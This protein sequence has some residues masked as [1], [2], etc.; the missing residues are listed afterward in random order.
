[1]FESGVEAGAPR[2]EQQLS[3]FLAENWPASSR[4]IAYDLYRR[5]IERRCLRWKITVPPLPERLTEWDRFLENAPANENLKKRIRSILL[6][7][8]V[9]TDQLAVFYAHKYRSAYITCYLLAAL[10]VF[11]ALF[12]LLLHVDPDESAKVLLV[13]KFI[14]VIIEFVFIITIIVVYTTGRKHLWHEKWLEYRAL[15][16]LLRDSRFLAFFAEYGSIQRADSFGSSSSTWLLWYLRATVRE[17][18]L[19]QGVLDGTYQSELLSSVQQH[20]IS[21]QLDYHRTNAHTLHRM[22]QLLH[23]FTDRCFLAT[24]L[25]LVMFL[26]C[27]PLYRSGWPIK[28]GVVESHA[29]WIS[30]LFTFFAAFLP[31]LGAAFAGIRET[32]DFHGFAQR[33]ARTV[34]NLENRESDLARAKRT[35]ALDDTRNVLVATSQVLTEDLAAWQSLYSEKRL[36]L[37]V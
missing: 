25:V 1:M 4:S 27:W 33:S 35:L 29:L 34:A 7:R 20:V 14:I 13:Q 15:A 9:W 26:L 5:L 19:P 21:D 28:R 12:G 32:G 11:I 17:L 22:S 18:G 30:N 31:A 16:E 2:V 37:P 8:Y 24:V 6:P 23:K 3:T 36:T 10:V